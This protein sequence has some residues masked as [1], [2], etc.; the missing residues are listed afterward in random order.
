MCYTM[1]NTW[2]MKKRLF[3]KAANSK[4]LIWFFWISNR[5]LLYEH[6]LDLYTK[7]HD[8][9]FIFVSTTCLRADDM[10]KS[11]FDFPKTSVFLEK[12][13]L[14][15]KRWSSIFTITNWT[16]TGLSAKY[17]REIKRK[18]KQKVLPTV[19]QKFPRLC[20]ILGL[21]HCY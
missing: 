10:S 17:T 4:I 21:I 1:N 9:I 13:R 20:T 11:L 12:W 6:T 16:N 5:F 14:V 19:S 2:S 3:I 7:F 8:Y 15:I 18:T